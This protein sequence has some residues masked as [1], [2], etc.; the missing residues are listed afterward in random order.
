[1]SVPMST[2]LVAYAVSNLEYR[3]STLRPN[4]VTFRT[5]ARPEALHQ[6]DFASNIGPRLLDYYEEYFDIKY[7]LPKQDMVAVPDFAA[8]AM[9]NWGLITYRETTLLYDPELSTPSNKLQV[10]AV[11]AHEL[12]HQ[13]FGNLVTMHWWTDLWLNEGFATYMSAV[14]LDH[15]FPEWRSLDEETANNLVGVLEFDSLQKSHP[16]SNQ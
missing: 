1:M 6:V 5:W 13:W 14:A 2:Y 4:N 11:V 10:A 15:L 16:V 12:A 3:T 7:P 8:G 9:E